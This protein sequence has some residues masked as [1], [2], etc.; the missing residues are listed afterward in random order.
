[1]LS[2]EEELAAFLREG[3]WFI[4]LQGGVIIL[5]NIESF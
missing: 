5:C 1:M 2:S 3:A 4:Q